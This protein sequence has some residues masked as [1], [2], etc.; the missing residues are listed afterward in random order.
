MTKDAAAPEDLPSAVIGGQEPSRDGSIVSV[1]RWAEPQ[2]PAPDPSPVRQA[3][4]AHRSFGHSPDR[5]QIVQD[6]AEAI[7]DAARRVLAGETLSSIIQVWNDRGLRTSTGGPWRVNSLSTLLLQPRLAGLDKNLAVL[8]TVVSKPILELDT[9]RRLVAL[10]DSRR[11]GPRRPTRQYLLTGLLRC[12]RCGGRLRGMPSSH[13]RDLYVCPGPPHGGCS[14]TAVT[15]DRADVTIRDLL[16]ARLDSDELL[17][18]T[19]SV[20]RRTSLLVETQ[21]AAEQVAGHRR[22]LQ[23]LAEMWAS[24]QIT[25]AEWMAARRNAVRWAQEAE[26]AQA[27]LARADDLRRLAGTG[28]VLRGRWAGMTTADRRDVLLTALDHVVVLAA[29][30]PRQVFRSDRLRPVW[31]Q[32]T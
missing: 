19:S 4:S 11:K 29:Q 9:Y 8:P 3:G 15:A 14:G 21:H 16:L 23:D 5:S 30:P 24:G 2:L 28:S 27:L 18:A 32:L 25:R 13:G 7:R 1:E 17:A 12:W 20:V 22:R 10:H 6:E 31:V 26:A